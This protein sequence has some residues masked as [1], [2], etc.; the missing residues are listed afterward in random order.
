MSNAQPWGGR[1]R[2]ELAEIAFRFSASIDIDQRLSRQDIAGSIAHAQ[3]LS[4]CGIITAEDGAAIKQGLIELAADLESGRVALPADAEDIHMAVEKL[5]IERIG[6]AGGRLHT[7]R[8]RNDQVALDMRLYLRQ[9]IEHLVGNI[10]QLQRSLLRQ[11]GLHA[12]TVMP[13]Y[14]HLQRAQP[15]LLGHH[16]LAYVQMLERDRSRLLDC[17]RRADASPL[18]AAALAGT[19]FPIDRH[20]VAANLGFA[21]IVENSMDAVSARDHLLEFVAACSIGMSTLSRLAEEVVLWATAEFRFI[22]IGDAFSTGSSIMPQKKNPDMAELVRGKTGRVFGALIALLTTV[23]GLPLSYNRDMQEDK[24][25]V[26]DSADT[27]GDSLAVMAGMLDNSTFNAS[28]MQEAAGGGFSTATELA[29]YLVRHGLPFRDAHGVAGAVVGYCAQRNLQLHDLDVATLQTFSP[30]FSDDIL[31]YLD[32]ATAIAQ[33]RSS[34]SASPQEVARQLEWWG[35]N[36]DRSE[37]T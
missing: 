6:P 35:K 24:L 20:A 18:G 11:A 4:D 33:R 36:L 13:G 27:W 10:R 3:M 16:L 12:G 9:T 26:F 28:A 32:P 8:S 17:Q 31:P 1:F 37:P 30:R 34:G 29:D 19:S 5:L 22:E 14:T 21:G 23:K 25:P 15:V 2:E 7:A